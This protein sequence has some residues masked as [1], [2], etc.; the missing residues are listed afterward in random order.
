MRQAGRYLP[1]YR[2]LRERAGS[3]LNLCYTPDLA[4]KVTLQPIRRFGFDAAILFADIL[5][6]PHALGQSLEFL[7][8][9]GPKLDPV[10]DRTSVAPLRKALE[11]G[12]MISALS[13][14]FETV[15]RVS[16]ELDDRTTL[17]GFC[18]APWTVATYMI[19]GRSEPDQV[20]ART[21]ALAGEEWFADL[22]D[23]LVDASAEYLCAQ[24]RAGAEVVQIFESWAGI[25]GAGSFSQWVIEPVARLVAKV[26][27]EFPEL[28][29]IGFPRG[30][31][32]NYLAFA[33]QSGIGA[34]S[35]D[36]MVPVHWIRDNLQQSH[37][38]QGNLDPVALLTGGGALDR[39]VDEILETL[40]DR[41]FIFNLGH[42]IFPQTP[43][44]HVTR[45]LDLIRQVR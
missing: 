5:L 41:P 16:G 24:V 1:E 10:R 14:V 36:H 30:A 9:E 43:I 42:G 37:V 27:M 40:G 4:A 18:G 45:V 19:Q 38:V 17:I 20:A 28:P 15:R 11:S 35:I 34:L 13:P 12:Q 25:L 22:I 23:L 8:G 7:E 21:A 6:I 26:R 3:F 32:V 39:A 31:G 2:E 33:E 29:I 44:A